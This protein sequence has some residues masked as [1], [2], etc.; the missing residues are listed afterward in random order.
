MNL[1][2]ACH[3][4]EIAV[5]ER[6][7]VPLSSSFLYVFFRIVFRNFC[8]VTSV[9]RSFDPK[10]TKIKPKPLCFVAKIL[11][12]FS[13]IANLLNKVAKCGYFCVLL[14]FYYLILIKIHILQFFKKKKSK[15]FFEK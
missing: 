4:P 6:A 1:F 14:H 10:I 2:P 8:F 15:L 3:R 9:A 5:S 11:S 13:K 7:L 12:Y